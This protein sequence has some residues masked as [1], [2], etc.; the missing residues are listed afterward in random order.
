MTGHLPMGGYKI[1]GLG[2]PTV[3]TDA[4]TKAYADAVVSGDAELAAIAGLTS[5]AD[6]L[7]YFTGSGTASL[8]T[9]TAAGRAI[10]DDADASA[11]RTTL[12]LGT[13]A[14]QAAADYA[15]LTGT[16][17]LTN[18][19]ITGATIKNG[20][21]STLISSTGVMDNITGI[22]LEPGSVFS[23]NGTTVV[24]ARKTGWGASGG[25]LT[26]TTFVTSTVTLEQLAERVAALITDLIDHG[27]IGA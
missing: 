1:T 25:T 22:D 12:G 24:E 6:R 2:T 5:A 7:P 4:A 17:T 14:T 18:K 23:I 27:L 10:V 19:T 8:A 26:R 11:Q 9:F 20:G 13:I 3:S 15:T 21:G 16:E